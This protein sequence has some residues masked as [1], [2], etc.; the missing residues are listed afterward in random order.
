MSI[1]THP[2]KS[3]ITYLFSKLL[4]LC[5]IIRMAN[6]LTTNL[7]QLQDKIKRDADGFRDEFETQVHRYKTSLELLQ[8][9]PDSDSQV[10]SAVKRIKSN[11]N[12]VRNDFLCGKLHII[13]KP[14]NVKI[15]EDSICSIIEHKY[16]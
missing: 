7:A 1:C 6:N 9:Y 10:Y 12:R 13:L 15:C 14:R 11:F 8:L 2:V 4:F 3:L 5:L 16:V